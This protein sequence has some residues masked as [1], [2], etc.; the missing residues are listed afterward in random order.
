[1]MRP[2]F[3]NTLHIIQPLEISSARLSKK[4]KGKER[5]GKD[6]Q[7][8]QSVEGWREHLAADLFH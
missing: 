3:T 1:M 4:K 6:R 2:C 7:L 5:K 8:L